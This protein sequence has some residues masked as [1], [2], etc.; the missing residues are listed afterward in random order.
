MN[1]FKTMVAG[2]GLL[3]SV[4]MIAPTAAS[5]QESSY[6]PGTVWEAGR[7]DVLPGQ[8]EN[9]MDWLATSWKK[10]QELGKAEGVVVEYH[11]LATN[12]PRAGEPDLILIVEYKDYQTTAQQEAMAKKVNA[13]MAYGDNRKATTASGERGKMR[14]QLGSTEYQELILK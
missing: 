12:N 9:Y 14:E 8:F 13:L 10:I 11:V 3:A 7:I 2:A 4:T 1:M 6:R 5:A